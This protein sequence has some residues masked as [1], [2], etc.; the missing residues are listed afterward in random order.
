MH[1]NKIYEKSITSGVFSTVFDKVYQNSYLGTFALARMIYY[2]KKKNTW[3]S[4]VNKFIA[5]THFSKSK[6]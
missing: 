5:L 2:H 1:K 6:F 4:K 3:N